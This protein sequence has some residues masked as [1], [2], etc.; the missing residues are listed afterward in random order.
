MV[1]V[2]VCLILAIGSPVPAGAADLVPCTAVTPPVGPV[3]EID[4]EASITLSAAATRKLKAGGVRTRL[5]KPANLDTGRPAYPVGAISFSKTSL[6]I[7]LKGG[8]KLLG[9]KSRT[10]PVKGLVAVVRVSGKTVINA[11]L[12]GGQKRL[13]E[14]RGAKVSRDLTAGTLDLSAGRAKMTP[15]A[16][17]TFNKRLGLTKKMRLKAGLDWGRLELFASRTVT[18]GE[19]DDPVG[20]AP[21][22]PPVKVRPAG[23]QDVTTGTIDWRVRESF[24]Q[25]VNSGAG[26]A[27]YDG[28]TAG[29]P[30][31]VGSAPPLTYGFFFPF[32]SGWSQDSDESATIY[33]SGAVGFK[34]C[35]NTINFTVADPEI[36]LDGD[37][38]SRI[39]F[40]VNGLD[41]TPFPHS[42]AVVVKLLPS[43]GTRTVSGNTVTISGIPGYIPEE[44][45]GIFAGFYPPYPGTPTDP[46][47]E[48]SKFG[49][50]TVS[51]TT[52]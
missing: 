43:F 40:R 2:L 6:R 50:I 1:G 25:Y 38:N 37:G 28:A 14:V 20:E 47:A 33:G 46:Q 26:A 5:I 3:V 24:I 36:E 8:F 13:F 32:S 16:A 4:G 18:P 34:N 41:G 45:T 23:A 21:Q 15:I 27:V 31:T 42:R 12:A 29:P 39:I 44:S 19:P 49:S 30:E 9:K 7:G 17:K 10:L 51:Y 22:E 11:K 48:F 35:R 52:P